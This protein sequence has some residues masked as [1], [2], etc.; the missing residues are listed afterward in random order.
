VYNRAGGINSVKAII[1]MPQQPPG[2]QPQVGGS[3]KNVDQCQQLM[4]TSAAGKGY[5]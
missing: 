3:V 4:K 2:Q 5:A 1:E